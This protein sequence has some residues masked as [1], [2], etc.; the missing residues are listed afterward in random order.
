MNTDLKTKYTIQN[1][2][3]IIVRDVPHGVVLNAANESNFK[4]IAT[5]SFVDNSR[6]FRLDRINAE[7]RMIDFHDNTSTRGNITECIDWYLFKNIPNVGDEM[8][9]EGIK[10]FVLRVNPDG[11]EFGYYKDSVGFFRN[12]GDKDFPIAI[13]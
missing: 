3:E 6:R 9:Y 7:Y 12:Y 11:C 2:N 4:L 13:K 1:F 8:Y 5:G 10:V